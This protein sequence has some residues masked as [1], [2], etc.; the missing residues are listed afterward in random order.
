MEKRRIMM[1]GDK[2][3]S[4]KLL[5]LA[6]VVLLIPAGVLGQNSAKILVVSG[7]SGPVSAPIPPNRDFTFN[8]KVQYSLASIDA[9]NLYVDVEEFQGPASGPNGCSG[10]VHSTNGGSSVP[11]KRG[12]DRFAIHPVTAGGNSAPSKLGPGEVT[13]KVSWDGAHPVYGANTKF[14]G[15]FVTFSDPNSGKVIFNTFPPAPSQCYA[16]GV[17]EL[18]P[19]E[20]KAR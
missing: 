16:V 1:I 7:A 10:P 14:I 20:K 2:I 18:R 17:S 11:I 19:D 6:G 15:L 4:L 8:T 3:G 13:V 9:A 5:A 12:S